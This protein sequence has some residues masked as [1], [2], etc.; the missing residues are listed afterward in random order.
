MGYIGIMEGFRFWGFKVSIG[1]IEGNNGLI[2][3]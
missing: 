1:I 2:W 3:Q